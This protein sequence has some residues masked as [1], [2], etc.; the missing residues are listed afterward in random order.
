MEAMAI[1]QLVLRNWELEGYWGRTR[2]R[3]PPRNGGNWPELDVV[4]MHARADGKVCVRVGETKVQMGPRHLY[5]LDDSVTTQGAHDWLGPWANFCRTVA[6]LY[7]D[8]EPQLPGLPAWDQLASLQLVLVFNGWEPEGAGAREG[9][10]REL[11]NKLREAWGYAKRP[12]WMEMI[13]CKVL[14]T[15]D[16]VTETIRLSNQQIVGGRGARFGD[17]FIDAIREVLRYLHAEPAWIPKVNGAKIAGGRPEVAEMIRR[18]A[19]QRLM[20][21]LDLG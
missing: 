7:W 20:E 14:T 4:A 9:L 2:Q 5:V 3:V 6:E 13:E 18:E 15:L 16:V 1:E 11:K 17:P 8:D 12:K 10:E 21:A 19:L